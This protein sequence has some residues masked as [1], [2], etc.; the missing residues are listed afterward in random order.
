MLKLTKKNTAKKVLHCFSCVKTGSLNHRLS[1]PS[2][3]SLYSAV[4]K[5][6]KKKSALILL[7]PKSHKICR[8]AARK[9]LKVS[10]I[11]RSSRV[12]TLLGSQLTNGKGALKGS[13]AR[14]GCEVAC[15]RVEVGGREKALEIGWRWGGEKRH[16]RL[17]AGPDVSPL[18]V[19]ARMDKRQ[20]CQ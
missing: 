1:F 8:S 15:V 14:R 4:C 7:G 9:P 18:C 19:G 16:W 12:V 20:L 5:E 3:L 2:S 13:V 10:F 11:C 6:K 17:A